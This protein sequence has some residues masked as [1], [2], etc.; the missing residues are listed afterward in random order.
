[1]DPSGE[2]RPGEE[3]L[4]RYPNLRHNLLSEAAAGVLLSGQGTHSWW[5]PQWGPYF[6]G[7]LARQS[8]GRW[9][10]C[11]FQKLCSLQSG[12]KSC[13]SWFRESLCPPAQCR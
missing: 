5:P 11:I 6:L 8:L 10:A 7:A 3:E 4:L 12:E 9:Q 13:L 1:M 2:A